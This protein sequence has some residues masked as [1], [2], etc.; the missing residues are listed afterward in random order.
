MQQN[1]SPLPWEWWTSN[2]HWRLSSA[3]GKDGDV[4]SAS[5]AID[6]MAVINVRPQDAA[7]IVKACNSHD[8]LKD[9]LQEAKALL[10]FNGIDIDDDADYGNGV[11][12]DIMARIA[13]ALAAAGAE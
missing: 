2:S 7:F 10:E 8:Q 5:R 11:A 3:D 9:A 13:V 1:I 4:I 6:G 12:G